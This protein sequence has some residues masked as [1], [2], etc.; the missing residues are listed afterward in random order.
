MSKNLFNPRCLIIHPKSHQQPNRNMR[1]GVRAWQAQWRPAKEER[2]EKILK[3]T[4]DPLSS[5]S[6]SYQP[7]LLFKI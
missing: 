1:T 4:K 5:Q 7:W 2:Q 6:I 3:G